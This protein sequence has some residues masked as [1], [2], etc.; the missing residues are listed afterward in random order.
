MSIEVG[1]V[2]TPGTALING[3]I[4]VKRGKSN[5]K[6]FPVLYSFQV[7]D[8]TRY[9]VT[10]DHTVVCITSLFNVARYTYSRGTKEKPEG[11]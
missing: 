9:Y 5:Q 7:R 2:L 6:P 4:L 1:H 8:T 11:K 3:V 10:F